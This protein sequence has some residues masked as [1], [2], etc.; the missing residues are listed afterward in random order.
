ME[1][2]L[3]RKN[4]LWEAQ[5][6]ERGKQHYLLMRQLD[7]SGLVR[8]DPSCRADDYDFEIFDDTEEFCDTDTKG[9]LDEEIDSHN[10]TLQSYRG[11]RN[12]MTT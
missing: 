3:T 9:P 7:P 1:T 11:S 2:E 12:K 8:E 5:V 4:K 6:D 10:L